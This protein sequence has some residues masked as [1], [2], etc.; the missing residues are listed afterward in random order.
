MSN[1]QP[2]LPKLTRAPFTAWLREWESSGDR[3]SLNPAEDSL[4]VTPPSGAYPFVGLMSNPFAAASTPSQFWPA[5]RMK[6]VLNY[7]T[8][9]IADRKGFLLLTGEA[10]TGKTTIAN[11]VREWLRRN[12]IPSAFLFNP[13]LDTANFFEFVAAEFGLPVEPSPPAIAMSR[14]FAWLLE[15]NRAAETPVLI[16]DEAQF[17]PVAVLQAIALLLS[18]EVSGTKLLHILL[19]G[20]PD[21]SDTLKRPE[22]Q[23]LRLAI[24]ARCA[25]SPLTT[26]E[27]RAYLELRLRA[28]GWDGNPVFS[29]E[30]I[31]SISLFSRGIPRVINLLCERSLVAANRRQI[32]P[33]PPGLVEDVAREFQ[34][35]RARPLPAPSAPDRY[36]N[37]PVAPPPVSPAP[38]APATAH[39][40]LLL[41][42][43][44]VDPPQSPHTG[45]DD[46]NA[47]KQT[48]SATIVLSQS[49]VPS[50]RGFEIQR[51][52]SPPAPPRCHGHAPGQR[53]WVAVPP[54][55]FWQPVAARLPEMPAAIAAAWRKFSSS[56]AHWLAKP[57]F[58]L[59]RR[60]H[61]HRRA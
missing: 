26:E 37:S 30:A 59:R 49:A 32:R 7:L 39:R 1:H 36:L 25:T 33:V 20:Q 35:D 46:S 16:I 31:L 44:D 34:F 8:Q 6:L 27:V 18:W 12:S 42:P 15:R 2:Q 22:L 14:L 3:E 43:L 45:D 60:Q 10:G 40:P 11:Q 47:I 48:E 41:L 24:G 21:L 23:K 56:L 5:C 29:E 55:P 28:A 52:A 17:L 54:S 9:A 53:V 50:P 38:H 58:S 19:V 4:A 51:I 61:L 13:L 57:M